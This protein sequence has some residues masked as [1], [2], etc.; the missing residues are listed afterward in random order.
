MRLL[1]RTLKVLATFGYILVLALY[2]AVRGVCYRM[3][4]RTRLPADLDQ[5]VRRLREDGFAILED[6]CPPAQVERIARVVEAHM[7]EEMGDYDHTNKVSYYR[8]PLSEQVWDG[9]V[10]RL[11]GVHALDPAILQF[12][13]DP[14]LKGIIEQAFHTVV[15][16]Q[17][18]MAQEN[19][20]Q[21][22]ETRGFHLDMY[23]PLEF[24]A[25]LFL[26]DVTEDR[27]GPYTILKGSHRWHRR[28]LLNYLVRGLG[29]RD[30]VSTVDNLSAEELAAQVKFKVSKGS[31]VLSIQQA[32]H[33]GWP[34]TEGKRLA[35]VNYYYEKIRPGSPDFEEHNRLGYRYPATPAQH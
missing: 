18:T 14:V 13:R 19:L 11:F 33:R 34:H 21:G 25:F 27:H 8:C 3:T 30:P 22:A 28:R 5:A 9:G 10:Y 1:K 12:R 20:P 16:C 26:T 7:R 29:G 35:V 2:S 23:A 31:V 32:I 4:R 24:K 17:V 15:T 6:Y